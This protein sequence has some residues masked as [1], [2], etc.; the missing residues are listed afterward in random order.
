MNL[1]QWHI[2]TRAQYSAGTPV[3][4]DLYF[5]SDEQLIYRGNV[6]YTK[7]M[8]FYSDTLPLNPAPN[9]IYVNSTTLE[10]SMWNGSSWTTVIRPIADT[11][12]A[13]GVNPVSGK[14]V[15]DYVAE[16]IQSITGSG[17]VLNGASWDGENHV[18]TFTKGDSSN[19]TLTLTGLGVSLDYS[20]DTGILRLLDASGTE[21]D[22][23]NMALERF[24]KSG[25][26]DDESK[27]IIL[28]F[29]DEKLDSV[30]IPV[31]DLVDTYTAQNS[32]TLTLTVLSN[33]I[34][35]A[36][37]IS[38]ESGNI[39]EAKSD[40]LYVPATDIS[41]KMDKDT[42]AVEG[43]VAVFDANGNVVDSG[44][45]IE[46]IGTSAEIFVGDSIENA[47]SGHTPKEG[48]FCIVTTPIGADTG[49]VER[50]AY[51]HNGTNWEALDGNYS[52]KNVYFPEDLLTTNA[53]GNISLSNGQATIS[54]A[55]KNIV[56]VWNTIFVKEKNPAVTQP[57]VSISAPNN[58]A[59]EV[60]TTVTPTFNASLNAGSY[61]YGPATGITA[62][63]WAIS[64]TDS[65]SATTNS[66]SFDALV[67]G[68][69]TNYTITA[70]ATYAD[71]A[72]PKTNVG[73]DYA[74]GQIKAGTKSAT[75]AAITG[76]RCGFYGTL[77][78]KDTLTSAAIRGLADKT[79]AAP[80]NNNVWNISVPVGA[81]RVV[82]A[83]PATR[84]DVVSCIDVGGMNADITSAFTKIQVDVE[85]ADGYTAVAYK[86]YY[87]DF[88]SA[89]DTANT[90]KVTL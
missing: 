10:G 55:G 72:I 85:G 18:L 62:S 15:T 56:D 75:S 27:T 74:T 13:E 6:L 66:G 24:V 34:S 37:N 47:T 36:V 33:V 12:T 68:D 4:N 8:E 14:A 30:S 69:S 48:D 9:R 16:Q 53:I 20:S 32:P 42:D 80:A 23:V 44:T 90:I 49:K 67:V 40:G 61:Q 64:D 54:A 17:S 88:A 84:R 38:A 5:I 86:V 7:S 29:D 52:A 2:V 83:F 31:G 21:L 65:H 57:S 70:T 22:T 28:Y 35:G 63:E 82:F 46:D 78:N 77:T 41:G 50:T 43:N 71:G 60:G 79:T 58:K 19:I 89:N 59:Y 87:L 73:N 25:E 51:I 39:L 76:Y 1:M 45:A 11:I 3:D 81:L 26:Y